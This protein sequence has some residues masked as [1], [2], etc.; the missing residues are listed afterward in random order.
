MF[1]HRS[2]PVYLLAWS[3]SR[4]YFATFYRF[5]VEGVSYVPR[6]GGF[7]LASNHASFYDPPVLGCGFPRPVHY[8]ARKTLF[9]GIFRWLLPQLNTIPVDRD[10][11]SDVTALKTV[12]RTLRE[13]EGIIFFPE[14]TRTSDGRLQEAKKGIGMIACKAGVPVIPARVF[15]TFE[16]FS[17]NHTIPTLG[18]RIQVAYG[19]PLPVTCFDPGRNDPDRYQTAANRIL[20]AVAAI[21]AP[22][23]PVL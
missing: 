7:I 4:W 15:G 19:R 22:V 13:G 12:F 16:T 17:R 1:E 10:G 23:Y 2:H 18:R 14:G 9:K 20:E 6:T 3:L 21:P 5:S 11:T 8:F